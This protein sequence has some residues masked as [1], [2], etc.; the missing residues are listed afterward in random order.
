MNSKKILFIFLFSAFF[1]PL[2]SA[3][4][5]LNLFVWTEN[6]TITVE[7]SLSGGR[8]LVHA[9]VTVVDANTGKKILSGE[10]DT[11]GIFSFSLPEE[12]ANQSLP[13]DIIVNGGD[14]HQAH[15]L[16]KADEYGGRAETIPPPLQKDNSRPAR[17]PDKGECSCLDKAEFEELL[18]SHLERKLAPIRNECRPSCQS[19]PV[20]QG[21]RCGNR[22]PA[23][24]C[25]LDGLVSQPQ[26]YGK[27][28]KRRTVK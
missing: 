19:V 11:D 8:T 6:K 12:I 1:W 21:H 26:T 16:L 24:M 28:Q 2:P 17:P 23:R 14:G 15:W 4:H 18:D 9:T 3:A 27:H 22:L 20:R 5:K 7:S 10:T 13:L 25:R